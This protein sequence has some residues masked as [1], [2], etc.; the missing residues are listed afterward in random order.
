VTPPSKPATRLRER[1][2]LEADSG[3]VFVWAE[4][5]GAGQSRDVLYQ[6][7]VEVSVRHLART[8]SVKAGSPGAV[9]MALA[10]GTTNLSPDQ[11]VWSL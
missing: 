8:K 1:D 6:I 9:P 2:L 5:A 7:Q 3:D 11:K 4:G 10:D